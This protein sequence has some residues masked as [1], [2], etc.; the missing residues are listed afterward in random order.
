MPPENVLI[1]WKISRSMPSSAASSAT[2]AAVARRHQP[3]RRR[4][5]VEAVQDRV[6]A[7]VLLGGQVQVEAG[8]LE[9]DPD[10]PAHRA[11]F[12]HDVVAVDRRAAAGRRERGGEDRDRR[13]LAGAVRAEQRE[14][15]AGPDVEGDA[16]DGV[17]LGLLV[18]L[19]QVLDVDHASSLRGRRG[20]DDHLQ[21]RAAWRQWRRQGV[22]SEDG[23]TD[24]EEVSA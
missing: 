17:A 7:D 14:E 15:L 13:G 3:E 19:R 10:P 1:G 20:R 21:G 8:P 2:C 12:G 6:E 11:G 23:R 18:A 16:V 22:G 5:R 9:D 4:V 24:A